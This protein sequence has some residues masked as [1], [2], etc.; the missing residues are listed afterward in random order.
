MLGWEN[1]NMR[2]NFFELSR[3]VHDHY[4]RQGHHIVR[5]GWSELRRA[6]QKARSASHA[7]CV[8]SL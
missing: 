1:D 4:L 5:K 6:G 7:G 8:D 2:E 3:E